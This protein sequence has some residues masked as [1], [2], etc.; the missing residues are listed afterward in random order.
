MLLCRHLS[1]TQKVGSVAL[2]C[3]TGRR[4]QSKEES[5]TQATRHRRS[6]SRSVSA[7][8]YMYPSKDGRISVVIAVEQLGHSV[9]ARTLMVTAT[10]YSRG[11]WCGVRRE[12][13]ADLGGLAVRYDLFSHLLFHQ[14]AHRKNGV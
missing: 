13:S 1:N 3:E 5:M 12:Q 7:T 10:R 6:N 11:A 9:H 4:G 14:F 8:A 2:Y